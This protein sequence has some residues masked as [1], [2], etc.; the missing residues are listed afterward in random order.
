MMRNKRG[1]LLADSITAIVV[2]L[3]KV[4]EIVKKPVNEMI[5]A[6][7]WSVF[8]A[9][10]NN[11]KHYDLVNE[12]AKSREGIMMAREAL[13]TISQ[14][15]HERARLRSQRIWEMDRVS[16]MNTI[17]ETSYNE[18]IDEGIKKGIKEG[19]KEVAKNMLKRGTPIEYV[20]EDTGLDESTVIEIKAK[21][22]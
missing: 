11:P 8:I 14:D 12:I 20:V 13:L 10:A 19:I 2:D 21:L 22:K 7:K 1:M 6:E 3:T 9:M 17:R 4:K 18:G 15:E 5:P 16:E